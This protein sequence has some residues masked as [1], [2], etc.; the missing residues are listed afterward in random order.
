MNTML[1]V[2]TVVSV[3]IAAVS[4]ATAW[5]VTRADRQRRVA[6]ITALRLAAGAQPDAESRPAPDI[7]PTPP[8]E[9]VLA[10]ASDAPAVGDRLFARDVAGSGGA[11]RQQWLMGTAALGAAAFLGL[12][13]TWY[14]GGRYAPSPSSSA[15]PLELV[16]LAHNRTD[17]LLA[18]TGLVRNPQTGRRIEKLEAE[19]RVFDATGILIATRSAQVDYLDLVPG[20]ESSFAVSVGE[21]S[22]AA[23]YRVSFRASGSML[24]HV[25]RRT[26]L[27]S[28]LHQTAEAR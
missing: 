18:V 11:A 8:T 23:R 24:P 2:V 3:A 22:T 15:V 20:Q 14:V 13:L 9:P 19:V 17:G 25:D 27:P 16:A 10:G 4:A 28:Q 7:A 21:A 1:L 26:N 6:R 5:R 12:G